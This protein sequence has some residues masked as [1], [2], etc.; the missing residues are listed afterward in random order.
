MKSLISLLLLLIVF[1]FPINITAQ[2]V[3]PK[4]K[5]QYM[6]SVAI[7]DKTGTIAGSGVIIQKGCE[8]RV[9]TAAHVIEYMNK[10]KE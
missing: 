7:T 5:R 1:V 6:S 3:N 4:I 8:L 9:L 2:P 10:E